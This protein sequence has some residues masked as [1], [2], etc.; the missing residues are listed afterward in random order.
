MKQFKSNTSP[1]V[2]TN[3]KN[4]LFHSRTIDWGKGYND[5]AGISYE[6]LSY[7]LN[8]WKNKFSWE[9]EEKKL[10]QYDQF[11]IKID[12]ID[13]HSLHIKSSQ[14]DAVPLMLIH[15]WPGSIFEFLGLIPLLTN[16][17]KNNLNGYN[18]FRSRVNRMG[19][20]FSNDSITCFVYDEK[21]N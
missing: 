20:L 10:N 16:P 8:Y 17:E 3:L 12:D 7:I 14:K 4:I 11:K 15:G 2:I 6:N 5:N 1:E 21:R 13:I 9:N 19:W 18:V